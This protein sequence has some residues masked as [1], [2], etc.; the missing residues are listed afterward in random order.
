MQSLAVGEARSPSMLMKLMGFSMT[1]FASLG[2]FGFFALQG[3]LLARMLGPE[4]RG[5]FAAAVMFPQALLYV[6]LLGA[7]ELF[8]GYA[9]QGMSNSALRRS[10]ARYGLVAGILSAMV[11][12]LL[13]LWLIPANMRE[14]L[15]WAVLCALTMPSQQMRLSVQAVDHGQGNFTRYNNVRLA[16]AAIFPL[17]LGIAF[18]VGWQ[19]LSHACILFVIAQVLGLWL[20]QFGM[21]ASWQGPTAVPVP[22]AIREARGLIGAWLSTEV[23]ERIDLVLMMILVANPETLGH[24]AAAIPIASLLIIVPNAVGLYAFKRG[25]RNEEPLSPGDAWRFLGLGVVIQTIMCG[26]MALVLPY[27][28]ELL[29][30]PAFGPTIQFAWLLLPAGAFRGLLQAAD[31]YLRA[32]KKPGKGVRARALAVTVLLLVCFT[33][34]PSLGPWSIPIALSLAQGL[35]FLLLSFEVIRD[36]QALA[37]AEM[38]V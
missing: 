13:D 20:I 37:K 24:Y 4:Q 8:A 18:L 29:Y 12:I 31:S 35:C 21:T 33:A 16:A 5:A 28:I 17:L 19:E 23:L 34:Q 6:G 1:L 7:P 9:A 14:H 26:V 32:R 10:A 2:S 3:I 15:P 11:C 38:R 36:A 27:A 22:Q 25:A 30:G